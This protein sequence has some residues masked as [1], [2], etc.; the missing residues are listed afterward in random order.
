MTRLSLLGF[1][2]ILASVLAGCPIWDE[3]SPP[4]G[5]CSS[6]NCPPPPTAG[7]CSKP[8]DC[9]VNETCGDDHQCHIGDCTIWG[10]S[11][12]YECVIDDDLTASCQPGGS[13]TGGHGGSGGN[14][15]GGAVYCGNPD[16]CATGETCA[17]DGT[18][19]PGSCQQEVDG[20]TLG[21]IHGYVCA[22]DGTCR[23]ENPAACGEDADCSHLGSGYLCVSGVCTAP[24]DQ[25]FDQTQCP[26]GNVCVEGKCTTSCSADTDCPDSYACDVTLGVCSI[27]QQPC[28]ITNDCGGPDLVCVDGA[29]VPRSDGATCPD[30]MVWVENGC[31]PTQSANFIC[32]A[33]GQQDVCA[34]GSICLHHSCYIA[35]SAPNQNACN[36][37]PPA[38]NQCKSVTTVSGTYSVCGSSVNLG[39]Q[40]GPTMPCA[41]GSLCIDGFCN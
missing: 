20:Q 14:G 4:I 26:S 15:G 1:A 35:C 37:L 6:Q 28:V 2:G 9:G 10:C 18:C 13:G 24:A 31:I 3:S 39:D 21:C 40:C 30:G 25:C 27:P 32:G 38:F 23:P 22:D 5:S 8:Q 33:D 41:P 36:G 17:P 16:D 34:Q 12:G 11:S 7:S 29:C 19:Q